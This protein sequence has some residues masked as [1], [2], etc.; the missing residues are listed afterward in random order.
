MLFLMYNTR[1]PRGFSRA[2]LIIYSV[3]AIVCTITFLLGCRLGSRIVE[4]PI[5]TYKRAPLARCSL[6]L[7]DVRSDDANTIP[8]LALATIFSFALRT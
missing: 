5:T 2:T 7:P 3:E 6:L 1:G 8:N 4:G